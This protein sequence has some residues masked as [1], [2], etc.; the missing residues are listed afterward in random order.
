MTV[1]FRRADGSIGGAQARVVDF[2]VPDTNDWLAVTS[3]PWWKTSHTPPPGR[4][5]VRQRARLVLVELKNA[6]DENATLWSAF[7][8]LQTYKSE[9][10]TLFAY[11]NALLVIS[12]GSG[13]AGRHASLAGNGS[14]LSL[15]APIH[16]E[17]PAPATMPE[18]EVLVWGRIRQNAAAH[19][20]SGLSGLRGR[21]RRQHGEEDGGLP[22]SFHAVNTALAETLRAA[23]DHAGEAQGRYESGRQPGGE[24]ADRRRRGGVAHAGFGQEPV[25][26]VLRGAGDPPSP[27]GQPD[28]VVLTDRKR[29]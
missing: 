26:G 29:P 15:C 25:H 16:G 13:C 7:H 27:H 12:D 20:G 28:G 8:Q 2:D 24:R 10:P 1:E 5:A 14:G 11:Q 21:R 23:R 18:M 9:L 6:A 19:P 22:P 17:A 4:G 3:S